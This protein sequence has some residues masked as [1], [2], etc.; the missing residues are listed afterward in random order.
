MAAPVLRVSAE[1]LARACALLRA[2]GIVAFP[3][4]TYYGLAVDPFN[5]AALQRLFKLKARPE[6]KPVLTLVRDRTQIPRLAVATPAPY[7]SLMRQYWP[8]PL[9]LI[10]PARL[11]LPSELTGGTGGIG[12]RQ[13]PNP[14]ANRLLDAWGGP[15]TATSCNRSG[16][17]PTSSARQAALFLTA[18]D[19]LVLDDGLTPGGAG[20]TVVDLHEGR[21]F[22]LRDGKIPFAFIQH[23]AAQYGG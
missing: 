4:E 8:G 2:G 22:C 9:T 3:T 21:L 11:D 18:A 19:G 23:A 1:T 15:L 10:F 13:S 5:Q 20:S 12:I 16:Q 17:A 6:S 7:D 14:V